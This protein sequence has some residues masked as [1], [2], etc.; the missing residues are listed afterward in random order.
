MRL[1]SQRAG[2]A[3]YTRNN[4][5]IGLVVL[6]VVVFGVVQGERR[7]VDDVR[8]VVTGQRVRAVEGSITFEPL[9]VVLS[10]TLELV[11]AT[12][13]CQNGEV[14]VLVSSQ[15]GAAVLRPCEI[16]FAIFVDTQHLLAAGGRRI[17]GADKFSVAIVGL[18]NHAGH[19]IVRPT[20]LHSRHVDLANLGYFTGDDHV[21]LERLPRHRDW[22]T[23][24]V[25]AR[26]RVYDGHEEC[27]VPLGG[28]WS[29]GRFLLI[30][31][32][33]PVT[34]GVF[35]S[36]FSVLLDLLFG[37]VRIE[38]KIQLTT[39]F[40]N[41][42]A[43]IG[44]VRDI[45]AKKGLADIH[46]GNFTRIEVRA[47]LAGIGKAP[48]NER[49]VLRVIKGD[50]QAPPGFRGAGSAWLQGVPAETSLAAIRIT[51]LNETRAGR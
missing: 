37:Q 4:R 39:A 51:A 38:I 15:V 31:A 49:A 47:H 42:D 25:L 46:R 22:V 28:S 44:L 17:G 3:I 27:V 43:F 29:P 6:R 19:R 32:R 50:A 21:L 33:P 20:V 45:V 16:N 13:L 35:D 26:P 40:S 14:H 41:L 23:F 7:G 48:I 24:D 8:L 9:I 18:Y 1:G 36:S 2:W 11:H 5:G 34:H 12:R 30:V 10:C